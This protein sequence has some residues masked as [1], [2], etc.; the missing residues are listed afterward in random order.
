MAAGLTLVADNLAR[1]AAEFDAVARQRIDAQALERFV[2]SDGELAGGDFTHEAAQALRYAGPWGQGFAEP[3]F[4]NVFAVES[5]RLV[6][7][8]HL[9]LRLRPDGGAAID[10]IA[11]DALESAPPPAR[12]RA[13]FQLDLNEWN[14]SENLQLLVKQIE[15]A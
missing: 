8:K 11:F 4:D 3:V 9:K 6:G 7:E 5:W 2:W 1:F 10:A 14:G 13:L 12:V 15:A